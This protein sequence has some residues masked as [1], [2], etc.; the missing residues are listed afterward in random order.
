LCSVNGTWVYVSHSQKIEHNSEF[1]V[2]NTRFKILCSNFE[3]IGTE[4]ENINDDLWFFKLY[5][6][7]EVSFIFRWSLLLFILWFLDLDS[8]GT[9]FPSMYLKFSHS[10]CFLRLN[11][12]I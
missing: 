3:A 9:A 5:R 2:N 6:S 7:I 12:F 11:F 8:V 1:K 4:N 10:E